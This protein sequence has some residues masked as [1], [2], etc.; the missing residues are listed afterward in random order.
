MAD[1]R[2]GVTLALCQACE[3]RRRTV[4]LGVGQVLVVRA[5]E[6]GLQLYAGLI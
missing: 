3:W 2:N 6:R 1:R 4:G 5:E